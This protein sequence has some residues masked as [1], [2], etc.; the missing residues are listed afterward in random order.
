MSYKNLHS[1]YGIPYNYESYES[2]EIAYA[3]RSSDEK[4]SEKGL[5]EKCKERV[6]TFLK[7]LSELVSIDSGSENKQGLS[8]V[9]NILENKLKSL[10]ASVTNINGTIVGNIKGNKGD[11]GDKGDNKNSVLLMAHYDT[12]FLVGEAKKRPFRIDGKRA[13]GPGVADD[14]GGIILILHCLELL[15]LNYTYPSLTILFNPDE[16][17]SSPTSSSLIKKLAKENSFVLSF[18]PVYENGVIVSTRGVA[19]LNLKVEG[20]SAHTGQSS[21][22]GINAALELCHKVVSLEN[23]GNSN[24]TDINWTILKSG[25]KSN[26]IPDKASAIADIRFSDL[27]ELDRISQQARQVMLTPFIKGTK[28]TISLE[29]RRLPFPENKGSEYLVSLAQ[30]INN[31]IGIPLSMLNMGFGTDASFAYQMGSLKPAVLEGLGVIGSELHTD[32]EWIDI[33]SIASRMYLVTRLIS[34]L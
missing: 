30:S 26:V 14:K 11:K 12:V 27:S 25:D 10:G 6:D 23:L 13:L 31:E 16:E 17:I 4:T 7:D 21:K 5:L 32:L 15:Q 3:Q 2:D 9:A 22:K 1:A 18:E 29:L 19:K 34:S 20:Q 8:V 24:G 28:T 33:S